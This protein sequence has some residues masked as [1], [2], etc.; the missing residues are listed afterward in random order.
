MGKIIEA[1][2]SD[3]A[4]EVIESTKVSPASNEAMEKLINVMTN[5]PTLVK[6]AN[7]GWQ[8]TALK[9]A[10]QW[11]IAKKA[12]DIYKVEKATFGDVIK[13]FSTNLPAVI[14]VVTLAL[15]ND[16]KRIEEEY[17][18]VYDTLMWESKPEEWATLLTEILQLLDVGFFFQITQT[19]DL[20][21]QTVLQKKMTMEEQK[22][23]LLARNGAK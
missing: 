7:I 12:C 6:L 18:R 22:Q 21:R 19:I 23:L 5:A 2:L 15:L 8:I 4:K 9:P 17:D 3:K 13:G 16:K 10:V 14:E 11:K 20:F 1:K